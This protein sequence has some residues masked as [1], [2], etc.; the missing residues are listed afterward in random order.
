M[1]SSAAGDHF[2]DA[3]VESSVVATLKGGRESRGKGGGGRQKSMTTQYSSH[4]YT[5]TGK[6]TS[7]RPRALIHSSISLSSQL[8]EFPALSTHRLHHH[9]ITIL[10]GT[11][12]LV[13]MASISCLATSAPCSGKAITSTQQQ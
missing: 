2:L 10:V 3:V 9:Y 8:E 1:L 5:R 13:K 12:H 4:L 7:M 11:T 6:E